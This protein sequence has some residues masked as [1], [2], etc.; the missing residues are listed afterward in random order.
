VKWEG[1]QRGNPF[2]KII[3]ATEKRPMDIRFGGKPS[4]GEKGQYG[5]VLCLDSCAVG[6]TSDAAYPTGTTQNK[7]VQFY[8]D[9]DV[10]PKDGARV[11]VI[12]RLAE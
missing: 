5:C 2:D 4:R 12:F 8:G 11:S 3:K 6:I 7:V 10:L 1:L 9:K